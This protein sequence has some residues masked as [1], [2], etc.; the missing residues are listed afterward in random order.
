MRGRKG[1]RLS[2]VEQMAMA[3]RGF[4]MQEEERERER[5]REKERENDMGFVDKF[6]QFGISVGGSFTFGRP[7]HVNANAKKYYI[8]D[9]EKERGSSQGSQ[10]RMSV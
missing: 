3:Q 9:A 5:E 10:R 7:S 4:E 6:R 2:V 8:D 1:R